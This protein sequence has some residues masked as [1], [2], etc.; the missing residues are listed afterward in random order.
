M[1]HIH[2][3][4]QRSQKILQCL[5]LPTEARDVVQVLL[6]YRNFAQVIIVDNSHRAVSLST[7]A[8]YPF[9]VTVV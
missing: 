3:T 4:V 5:Q 7:D 9:G 2:L 6:I 8:T 1:K